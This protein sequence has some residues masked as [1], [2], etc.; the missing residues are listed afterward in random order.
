[1]PVV[2]FASILSLSPSAALAKKVIVAPF[3]IT[4]GSINI[5]TTS[6]RNIQDMPFN[7]PCVIPQSKTVNLTIQCH[8]KNGLTVSRDNNKA[9]AAIYNYNSI[10]I[11][12]QKGQIA[13]DPMTIFRTRD[14][15]LVMTAEVT[16]S[17]RYSEKQTMILEKNSRG[18]T[19]D[20]LPFEWDGTSP[21]GC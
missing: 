21:D 1:M 12:S 3:Q 6:F 17:A 20:V 18:T 11:Y 10:S 14:G 19:C 2:L 16:Y 15:S 9:T 7:V 8:G 13:Q 4:C 5:A